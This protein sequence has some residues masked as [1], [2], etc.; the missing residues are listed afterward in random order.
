MNLLTMRGLSS[1]MTL[2]DRRSMAEAVETVTEIQGTITVMAAGRTIEDV[3]VVEVAGIVK[4]KT[5]EAEIGT[6]TT[7]LVAQN[8]DKITRADTIEA[9]IATG[10]AENEASADFSK[11]KIS[12]HLKKFQTIIFRVPRN[13]V[14]RLIVTTPSLC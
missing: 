1:P 11:M 12:F 6:D 2:K 5:E 3:E 4:A 14:I 7:T 9:L 13:K 8:T 10:R